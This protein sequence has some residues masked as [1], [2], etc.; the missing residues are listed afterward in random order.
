MMSAFDQIATS[1]TN[2]GSA[3]AYLPNHGTV[4]GAERTLVRIDTAWS[5]F[6]DDAMCKSCLDLLVQ[7]LNQSLSS[8]SGAS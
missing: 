6:D 4:C 5:S 3:H 7:A 2:D 1:L 8:P